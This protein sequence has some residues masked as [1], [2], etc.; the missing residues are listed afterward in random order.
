MTSDILGRTVEA[1]LSSLPEGAP[2]PRI[3][4]TAAPV[5]SGPPRQEGT[6]RVIAVRD[7]E[8]IAARFQTKIRSGEQ[9]TLSRG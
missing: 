8:W 4:V 5:R 3:T 9:E 7:G 2:Q 6:L 1:A